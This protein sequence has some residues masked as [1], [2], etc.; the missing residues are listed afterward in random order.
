[1]P[2]GGRHHRRPRS[3]TAARS[4][5]TLPPETLPRGS[6]RPARRPA[7]HQERVKTAEVRQCGQ[8]AGPV[9]MGIGESGDGARCRVPETERCPPPCGNSVTTRTDDRGDHGRIRRRRA[10]LPRRAVQCR[11]D[12]G[13]RFLAPRPARRSRA[14]QLRRARAWRRSGRWRRAGHGRGFPG[15]RDRLVHEPHRFGARTSSGRARH[16]PERP[17]RRRARRRAAPLLECHPDPGAASSEPLSRPATAVPARLRGPD[18][19]HPHGSVSTTFGQAEVAA[20]DGSTAV[21]QVRQHG[22]DD[23]RSGST[24]L[25]YAFDEDGEFFWV[26]PFDPALDPRATA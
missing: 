25:L 21:V 15:D 11:S 12:R 10:R 1:M 6:S 22:H 2:L 8:T 19:H 5:T 18:L 14:R 9:R 20:A 26:A 17:R 23:L 16:G 3:G 4:M 7:R 24:A 13:R